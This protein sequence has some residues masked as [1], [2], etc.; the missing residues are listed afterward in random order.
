MKFLLPLLCLSLN[1]IGQDTVY[2]VSGYSKITHIESF[3]K[4][5]KS[6]KFDSVNFQGA[7]L[8]LERRGDVYYFPKIIGDTLLR[9]SLSI[10]IILDTIYG[11]CNVGEKI[12]DTVIESKT[13]SI[14]FKGGATG[15]Y[16]H[17]INLCNRQIVDHLVIHMPDTPIPEKG[18]RPEYLDVKR[19][20]YDISIVKRQATYSN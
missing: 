19:V 14:G 5:A 7:F 11:V 9:T 17:E 15:F 10:D 12:I 1:C 4:V 18:I 13:E 20:S 8:R 6:T 3:Q 16:S 2:M